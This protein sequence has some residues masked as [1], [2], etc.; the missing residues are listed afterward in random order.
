MPNRQQFFGDKIFRTNKT[1]L[2]RRLLV[3]R[4]SQV[5]SL[6]LL[7][8]T[9]QNKKKKT[10]LILPLSEILGTFFSH[11][12]SHWKGGR[13]SNYDVG[14]YYLPFNAHILRLLLINLRNNSLRKH[15][16]LLSKL[17]RVV[18]LQTLKIFITAAALPPLIS[19]SIFF[20]PTCK[21]GARSH[22]DH[23]WLSHE[24]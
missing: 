8:N 11:F 14:A 4:Q 13:G 24:D 5:L 9:F 22:F 10:N 12:S 3:R 2:L 23:V 20:L 7:K 17:R 19:N 21:H 18:C 6:L 1:Y 15:S 16:H